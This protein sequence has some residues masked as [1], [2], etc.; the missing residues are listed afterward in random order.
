MYSRDN[1]IPQNQFPSSRRRGVTAVG[2][3]EAHPRSATAG[4]GM[5]PS[6]LTWSD[7]ER[8]TQ[9]QL[10]RTV[11]TPCPFCSHTRRNGNQRKL[12]FAVK[13]KEPDFA[14]YNCAHCGE[15]GYV[16]PDRPSRIVDPTERKRLG[17]EAERRE[18]EDKQERIA[19]ALKLWSERQPFRAAQRKRI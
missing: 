3:D 12:V 13:L 16:H 6:A 19:Y 4:R 15:S 2:D 7:V 10:G 17:E 1:S 18:S 14:I 9:G 8:T 5:L 11:R